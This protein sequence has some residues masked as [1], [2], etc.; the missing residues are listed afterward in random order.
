MW[1][2][3]RNEYECVVI[4]LRNEWINLAKTLG[5]FIT[6]HSEYKWDAQGNLHWDYFLM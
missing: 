5:I 6:V 1:R 3:E 4:S 2:R